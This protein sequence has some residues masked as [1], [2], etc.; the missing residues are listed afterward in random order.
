LISTLIGL[1]ITGIAVVSDADKIRQNDALKDLVKEELRKSNESISKM[2]DLALE[3]LLKAAQRT[4]EAESAAKKS[5]KIAKKAA[6]VLKGFS[7]LIKD[8]NDENLVI[9][10]DDLN[11]AMEDAV[12]NA[13]KQRDYRC[14]HN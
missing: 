7:F 10:Y 14:N 1:I 6:K 8:K 11:T 5:N 4:Y 2:G 3:N 12:V 13:F 9:T